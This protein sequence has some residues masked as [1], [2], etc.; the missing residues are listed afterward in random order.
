MNKRLF[1]SSLILAGGSLLG[2][3]AQAAAPVGMNGTMLVD[4][5]GMTL[6]TFDKD[7]ANSGKSVCN[8]GCATN[9]PP[10]KA[11]EHAKAS[12]NFTLV[13]RDD[14]TMQWAHKGKPLYHFASDKKP[15]DKSGDNFKNM[16]RTAQE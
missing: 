12:G 1:I 16:W 10:L 3:A 5:A 15:G 4:K 14:G 9:W 13:K 2:L 7:A 6:Y 8:G 11:D